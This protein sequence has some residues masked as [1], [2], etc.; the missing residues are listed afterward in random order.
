MIRDYSFTEQLLLRENIFH[1]AIKLNSNCIK[2]C[3]DFQE[4]EIQELFKIESVDSIHGC[5]WIDIHCN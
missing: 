4:E 5:S 2:S 3:Q 1:E